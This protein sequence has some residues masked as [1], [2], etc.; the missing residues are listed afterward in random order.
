MLDKMPGMGAWPAGASSM[1]DDSRFKQMEVIIDSMTA[2]ERANPDLLM[3]Q[4]RGESLGF[5]NTNSGP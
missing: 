4:E 3:D 5:R 2:K 1:V